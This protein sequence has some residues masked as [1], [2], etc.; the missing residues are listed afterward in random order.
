MRPWTEG[1]VRD[2][3]GKPYKMKF[4]GGVYSCTCMAWKAQSKKIDLRTCKHLRLE[5]G[6]AF[7]E[8]RI[9]GDI[10]GGKPVTLPVGTPA[11]QC[12]CHKGSTCDI[13]HDPAACSCAQC[14]AASGGGTGALATPTVAEV[15]ARPGEARG[16]PATG[17][18]GAAARDKA[19]RVNRFGGFIPFSEE[20]KAVIVAEEEARKGRKLRQDEKTDLFGPP[21]LLAN[22]VEDDFD[23][24]GWLES[25]KL[26]GVRA[27]WNGE[28]FI[29]RQGNV[30]A[31][32]EF[33]TAGLPQEPLDGELWMGRKMFQ[34]TISVVKSAGSGR[35]WEQVRFVVFDAPNF[36]GG[37]EQRL[38][39][40]CGLSSMKYA[41]A[42]SHGVCKS[43]QEAEANLKAAAAAGAEGLMFRK[44]GSQY[45]PRRS[46]TLL[47]F[48]PFQDAEATVIGYE[49]GKKANKGKTGGLIVLMPNG[50]TFNVGTGLTARDRENPPAVGS[51]ITYRFTEL[52]ND[53]IPKCASYVTT[54]DYE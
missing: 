36:P 35:A 27:Y 39:H 50:K 45:E 22:T 44:P 21:V 32:P 12:N 53:G 43:R 54:R 1:E 25:E 7:E 38:T 28:M 14:S 16:D 34:K 30:Y 10:S 52:T 15:A 40:L 4:T 47:K 46:S 26:D 9:S 37:F 31:A 19:R 49:P 33:F 17:Q 3:P 20:E 24:T 42:H 6:A 51:T 48:K 18:S 13:S 5:N 11:P 8:T 2:V 23:P 29:S 41:Y